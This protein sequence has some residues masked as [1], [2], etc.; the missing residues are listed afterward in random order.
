MTKTELLQSLTAS[1]DDPRDFDVGDFVVFKDRM[2]NKKSGLVLV[3]R[4][5]PKLVHDTEQG[6]GSLYFREP[7]DMVATRFDSDGDLAEFHMDSRRL[8]KATQAEI[9]EFNES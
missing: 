2:E 3:S 4:F 7:L 5:L 6:S 8:R 1:L 9:D